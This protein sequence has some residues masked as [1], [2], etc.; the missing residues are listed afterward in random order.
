MSRG[1]APPRNVHGS[2]RLVAWVGRLS[3]SI[4]IWQSALFVARYRIPSDLQVFPLNVVALL[5]VA[6]FSY[7]VV[8]RPLVRLGQRIS[9]RNEERIR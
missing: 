1:V 8:E 2:V 9:K 7:Y 4:Y 3:Y 5:A 6:S